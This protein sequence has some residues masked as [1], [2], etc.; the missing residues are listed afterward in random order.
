[1]LWLC[2]FEAVE[3]YPWK[4]T[5]KFAFLVFLLLVLRN[6][7]STT[8]LIL[9]AT[10]LHISHLLHYQTSNWIWL[11]INIR[12]LH[13]TLIILHLDT[14]RYWFYYCLLRYNSSFATD[15]KIKNHT[16]VKKVGYTS[17]FLFGIYWRTWKT[18]NYLKNYWSGPIKNKIILIFTMLHFFSRKIDKNTCRFRYQNLNDMIY[19]FSD[20]EQ[21]ILK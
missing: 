10:L 8:N 3:P 11:C 12:N 4:R 5:I 1:M 21:N 16:H 9:V 18:N 15:L 13:V 20:R 14:F 19:N 7:W 17:E 2:S 6:V